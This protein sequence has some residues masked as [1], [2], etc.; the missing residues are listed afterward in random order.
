VLRLYRFIGEEYG[1]IAQ[2]MTANRVHPRHSDAM[3]SNRKHYV[4]CFKDVTL[5][6]VCTEMQETQFS[7][8]EIEALVSQQVGYLA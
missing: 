5:D 1:L 3:Y 6:V 7:V 8:S 2:L 4:A